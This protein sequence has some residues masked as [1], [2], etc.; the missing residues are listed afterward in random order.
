M[1]QF[2]SGIWAEKG[3]KLT[4]SNPEQQQMQIAIH[5]QFVNNPIG[6]LSRQQGILNHNKSDTR[7]GT[8]IFIHKQNNKIILAFK[9]RYN[10]DKT[11]PLPSISNI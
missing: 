7:Y 3:I 1:K 6:S 5:I 11:N 2:F 8:N 9:I 10:N 4:N